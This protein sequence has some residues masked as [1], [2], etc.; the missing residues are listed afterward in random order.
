MYRFQS[1]SSIPDARDLKSHSIKNARNY[2]YKELT[3]RFIDEIMLEINYRVKELND[4][5]GEELP[6]RMHLAFITY[7]VPPSVLG[8]PSYDPMDF[9]KI[10]ILK[11]KKMHYFV[12][13]N[14]KSPLSLTISWNVV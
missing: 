12:S 3:K 2:L 14:E 10:L 4:M 13:W 9:V 8:R 11:F 5:Y 6:H 7:T 1:T